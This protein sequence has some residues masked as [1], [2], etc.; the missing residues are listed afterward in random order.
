MWFLQHYFRQCRFQ[1]I[2]FDTD[3]ILYITWNMYTIYDWQLLVVESQQKKN[4]HILRSCLTGMGAIISLCLCKWNNPDIWS[5]VI[6]A[7]QN[8]LL[9]CN[10]STLLVLMTPIYVSVVRIPSTMCFWKC[11]AIRY[12]N[13]PAYGPYNRCRASIRYY[14]RIIKLTNVTSKGT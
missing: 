7:G 5:A 6:C 2:M 9:P 11:Q 1:F 14:L 3:V 10:L 4:N 12:S 13:K 8:C